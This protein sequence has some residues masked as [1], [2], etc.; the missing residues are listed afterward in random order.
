MA[1]RLTVAVALV[2]LSAARPI[3]QAPGIGMAFEGGRVTI[4]ATDVLVSD[5]L[6]EWGRAG[7]TIVKGAETLPA[8]RIS[9]RLVDTPEVEALQSILGSSGG[10]IFTRH[11]ERAAGR[12]DLKS[13]TVSPSSGKPP[14]PVQA[15][16]APQQ[17]VE[18]MPE[19][20]YSYGTP[21][22]DQTEIILQ[23]RADAAANAPPP[24]SPEEA[25]IMPELRFQYAES[26]VPPVIP[27]VDAEETKPEEAKPDAKPDPKSDPKTRKPPPEI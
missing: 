8:A 21:A 27:G 7:G 23:E 24:L 13:L 5:V 20:R 3:A 2:V 26:P 11:G 16:A 25:K 12:S 18:D 19:T 17:P 9:L 22:A 15:A 4:V 10:Y 6:N 1:R 14:V